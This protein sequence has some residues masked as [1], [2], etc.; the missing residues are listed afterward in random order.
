MG[1]QPLRIAFVDDDEDD[2]HIFSEAIQSLNRDYV[3]FHA[4]QCNDLFDLLKRETIDIIFLD[5]RMPLRNGHECLKDI[6]ATAN[7]AQ[8]PV[9]IFS[10][11]RHDHDI[12]EAYEAGAQNYIIKPADYGAIVNAIQKVLM[13]DWQKADRK[14]PREEFV[15]DEVEM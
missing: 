13:S 5:I 11:S 3:L 1:E 12:D 6:K 14:P 9:I 15:I 8:I 4:Y 2:H 7:L 10:T